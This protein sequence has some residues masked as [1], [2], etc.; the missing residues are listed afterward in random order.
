M[1][2]LIRSQYPELTATQVKQILMDSSVKF[3]LMVQVLGEKEGT[4]KYFSE[5]SKSGGVLN[6]YNALLMAE[7]LSKKRKAKNNLKTITV[8][9]KE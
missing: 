7:K 9:N 3:D 6:A 1:A 5:L 8:L 2:A 4:L